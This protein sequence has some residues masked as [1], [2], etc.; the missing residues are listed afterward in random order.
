[1]STNIPLNCTPK[2]DWKKY[3]LCQTDTKEL[4]SLTTRYGCSYEGYSMIAKKNYHNFRQYTSYRTSLDPSRLDEEDGIQDTL[5]R[6]SDKYDQNFRK[7]LT[8]INSGVP[9]KEPL[10]FKMI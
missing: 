9:L 5:K 3:C 7:C 1:M 8:A 4:K 2:T 10:K 6:N